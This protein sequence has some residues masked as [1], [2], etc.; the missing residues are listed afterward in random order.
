LSVIDRLTWLPRVEHA[1]GYVQRMYA[2][3]FNGV[4]PQTNCSDEV[5]ANMV[6]VKWDTKNKRAKYEVT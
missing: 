2:T 1:V 6:E 3:L 5:K 4:T